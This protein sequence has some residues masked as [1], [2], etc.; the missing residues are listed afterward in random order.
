[1]AAATAAARARL[2]GAAL[3][4]ILPCQPW[5]VSATACWPHRLYFPEGLALPVIVVYLMSRVMGSG[6]L[7]CRRLSPQELELVAARER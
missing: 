4:G 1:M 6:H 3:G 7:A 2:S 5:S